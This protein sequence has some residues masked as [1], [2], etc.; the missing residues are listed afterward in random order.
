MYI[1]VGFIHVQA[2]TRLLD[3]CEEHVIRRAGGN[4]VGL[5]GTRGRKGVSRAELGEELGESSAEMG[6]WRGKRSKFKAL[7][8]EVIAR[9]RAL[10]YAPETLRFRFLFLPHT[11]LR[12]PPLKLFP[13][14]LPGSPASSSPAHPK[15]FPNSHHLPPPP[16]KSH[17]VPPTSA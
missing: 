15:S 12:P 16:T 1:A 6:G 5:G 13:L 9:R 7:A 4:W 3:R 17:Q 14:I 11:H 10:S 8:Y 2:C